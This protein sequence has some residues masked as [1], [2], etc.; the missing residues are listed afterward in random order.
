MGCMCWHRRRWVKPWSGPSDD[1][2]LETLPL[3][4]KTVTCCYHSP[5][6]HTHLC[7]RPWPH[8]AIHRKCERYSI[9]YMYLSAVRLLLLW[10]NQLL[11]RLSKEQRG[12]SRVEYSGNPK[13]GPRVTQLFVQ[14]THLKNKTKLHL[15]DVSFRHL[16]LQEL[17]LIRTTF[18]K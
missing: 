18:K 17:H 16:Q 2:Y 7:P 15:Q 8:D 10:L 12:S 14:P 3:N 5:P 1:N 11:R 4:T 13:L 9:M 6:H